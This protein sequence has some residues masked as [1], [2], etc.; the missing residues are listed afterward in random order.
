MTDL[1]FI[2]I[3]SSAKIVDAQG[4]WHIK[5]F[6]MFSSF[7]ALDTLVLESYNS[8]KLIWQFENSTK[9]GASVP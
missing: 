9:L 5:N 8:D 4:F 3:G 6:R 7:K 2:I 1:P